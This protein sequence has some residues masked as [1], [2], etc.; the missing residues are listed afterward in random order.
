MSRAGMIVAGIY[1]VVALAVIVWDETAST[2]GGWIALRHLGAK[3]AT[4]PAAGPLSLIG[5][6]LN[7]DSKL[8]IAALLAASTAIVYRV[9]SLI[10]WFFASR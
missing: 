3:L 4:I 8:T 1:F 9:V 2:G 5:F 7:F 6:D 10:A